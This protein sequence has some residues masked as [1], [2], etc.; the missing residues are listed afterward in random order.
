L[1]DPELALAKRGSHFACTSGEAKLL[2]QADP[3]G[4]QWYIWP[5]LESP[6]EIRLTTFIRSTKVPP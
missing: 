6:A 3:A 5:M 4:V 2:Q 1:V